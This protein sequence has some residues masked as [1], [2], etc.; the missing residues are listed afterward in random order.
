MGRRR[1]ALG[2]ALCLLV[3][4]P[5]AWSLY[6][7]REL[8]A[9]V[10]APP[11]LSFQVENAR[12][13]YDR[14][15]ASQSFQSL[16]TSSPYLAFWDTDQGRMLETVRHGLSVVLRDDPIDLLL[17]AIGRR[18]HGALWIRPTGGQAVALIALPEE[19]TD[20]ADL[21]KRLALLSK[22]NKRIVVKKV[23]DFSALD[24]GGNTLL[25]GNGVVTIASSTSMAL[26]IA[27]EWNAALGS[28]PPGYGH[29]ELRI[30]P[31]AAHLA[32]TG[33]ADGL[34]GLLSLIVA[35]GVASAL[36]ASHEVVGRVAPLPGGLRLEAHVDAGLR[37]MDERTRRIYAPA[38]FAPGPAAPG[39]ILR[40]QIARDL[41]LLW[42]DRHRVTPETLEGLGKIESLLQ[43]PSLFRDLFTGLEPGLTIVAAPQSFDDPDW[44]APESPFPGLALTVRLK[45]PEQLGPR[46]T[47]AFESVVQL[48]NEKP[49]D[50]HQPPLLV[51]DL[52]GSHGV[53]GARARFVAPPA[54]GPRIPETLRNLTPSIG[55]R[56]GVLALATSSSLVRD[57]LSHEA[58]PPIEGTARDTLHVDAQRAANALQAARTALVQ[59]DV[60]KGRPLAEA[61]SNIDTLLAILGT[62]DSLDAELAYGDDDTRL[63]IELRE[64]SHGE[65]AAAAAGAR[66]AGSTDR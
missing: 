34:G 12:E 16:Q 57:L 50:I 53:M 56:D 59:S 19:G 55:H 39:E 37:A 46:L 11:A 24:L 44:P 40:A 15:L 28:D 64:R 31:H 36:G 32:P 43:T 21:A 13:L 51:D 63:S 22:T 62:L 2:I 35:G 8:L 26:R 23:E 54:G 65:P 48:A 66:P 14:F 4:V 6:R 47:A 1:V 61:E 27:R 7:Q 20:V 30:D 29:L 41:D 42:E 3:A 38:T 60:E 45:D 10:D 25:L 9:L 33:A 17:Q 52:V 18:A 58:P 5:L 49:A